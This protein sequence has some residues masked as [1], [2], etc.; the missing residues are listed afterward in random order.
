M[1]L[2]LLIGRYRIDRRGDGV[3]VF[4]ARHDPVTFEDAVVVL[5]R[6]SFRPMRRNTDWG[7]WMV[8]CSPFDDAK[9]DGT[10]GSGTKTC[11]N[12]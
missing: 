11:M 12:T 6:E 7:Y 9:P 1:I 2:L 8:I 5:R 4:H 3:P 10:V